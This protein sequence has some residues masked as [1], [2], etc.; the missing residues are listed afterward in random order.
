[1]KQWEDRFRFAAIL[2]VLVMQM[3]WIITAID[4]LAS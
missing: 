1:M 3:I 2:L 4:R